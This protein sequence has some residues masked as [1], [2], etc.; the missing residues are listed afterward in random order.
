MLLWTIG[1]VAFIGS[2]L[3]GDD[4]YA[5]AGSILFFVGIVVFAVPLFQD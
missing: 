4:P 5:L 2:A 3:R 1:S